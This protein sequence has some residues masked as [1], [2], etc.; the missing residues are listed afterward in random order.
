MTRTRSPSL[1][2]IPHLEHNPKKMQWQ[3]SG[4]THWLIC[5]GCPL[6]SSVSRMRSKDEGES[7]RSRCHLVTGLSPGRH[8][9]K[10]KIWRADQG[11]HHVPSRYSWASHHFFHEAPHCHSPPVLT[12]TSVTVAP[13]KARSLIWRQ[14]NHHMRLKARITLLEDSVLEHVLL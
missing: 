10:M 4:D 1:S 2:D 5:R 3:W 7:W 11:L 14:G 8:Q 6:H 9:H 13:S 12:V